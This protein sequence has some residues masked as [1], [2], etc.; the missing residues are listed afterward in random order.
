MNKKNITSPIYHAYEKVKQGYRF[1][2]GVFHN[3]LRQS[4]KEVTYNNICVPANLGEDSNDYITH[5][6]VG[7]AKD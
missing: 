4:N 5:I 3:E 1:F 7:R 2:C 6:H